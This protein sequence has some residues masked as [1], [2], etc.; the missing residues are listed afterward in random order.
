MQLTKFDHSCVLLDDGTTKILFD[1]GSYSTIP[2]LKVDAIVI[3]HVHQDHL[4]VENIK[5]LQQA[6]P[7]VRIITNKEVQAELQKNNVNSE[8]VEDGQETTIGSFNIKGMGN[9]HAMI[10]PTWP[11][12]QNTAYLVNDKILH[13]GDALY[14][15]SVPVE[16]LLLP[17]VAP[18]SKISETLDYI[19]AI[20]PKTIVPIHDGFLKTPGLFYGMTGQWANNHGANLI[21]I[22]SNKQYEV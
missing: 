22:E 21:E 15:P 3:T 9:D 1:P 16:T 7:E 11:I 20:K 10:H 19:T 17:I 5:K 12:A 14:V 2:D 18:W 6:N 13:P 8:L 4:D